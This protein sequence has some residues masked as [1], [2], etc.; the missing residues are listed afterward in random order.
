MQARV[1]AVCGI[2]MLLLLVL[3]FS[4]G[5]EAVHQ[6]RR[7]GLPSRWSVASGD[8]ALDASSRSEPHEST[9]KTKSRT[10]AKSESSMSS[11]EKTLFDGADG[12]DGE[13]LTSPEPMLEST[14]ASDALVVE[15]LPPKSTVAPTAVPEDGP[16]CMPAGFEVF[17]KQLD[18]C[19]AGEQ[20]KTT[21]EHSV[22]P[23]RAFSTKLRFVFGA[24]LLGGGQEYWQRI[25]SDCVRQGVC[26]C[27]PKLDSAIFSTYGI[28][29]VAL[30][31]KEEVQMEQSMR[32]RSDEL[33]AAIRAVQEDASRSGIILLNFPQACNGKVHSEPVPWRTMATFPY[34]GYTRRSDVTVRHP[35]L[36]HLATVFEEHNA[37]LR[38]LVLGVSPLHQFNAVQKLLETP[39][40]PKTILSQRILTSEVMLISP[41]FSRCLTHTATPS[42]QE[43][44]GTVES[45]QHGMTGFKPWSPSP[46]LLK[47][48]S[49]ELPNEN[50]EPETVFALQGQIVSS[51]WLGLL[52]AHLNAA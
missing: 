11:T 48:L 2:G 47:P 13:S 21:F 15:E 46:E 16:K 3:L 18:E 29:P 5:D 17:S 45:I 8:A 27:A 31:Q 26:S 12:A 33:P 25:F 42:A 38:V 34:E 35:H 43:I 52:C 44:L 22:L 28:E 39:I 1:A 10:Q 6:P 20:D 7:V 9:R 19:E 41:A 49:R 24:G 4:S 30:A 14:A 50:V 36:R 32:F 51:K 23:K 40:T 37:D